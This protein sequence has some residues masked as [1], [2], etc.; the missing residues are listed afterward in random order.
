MG[1]NILVKFFRYLCGSSK[2]P[3]PIQYMSSSNSNLTVLMYKGTEEFMFQVPIIIIIF[4]VMLEQLAIIGA[5]SSEA[6][7]EFVFGNDST[8]HATQLETRFMVKGLSLIWKCLVIFS[9]LG[10]FVSKQAVVGKGSLMIQVGCDGQLSTTIC[11]GDH[12]LVSQC[13]G[14]I[15]SVQPLI[16]CFYCYF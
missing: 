10:P 2:S 14:C 5:I 16:D 8:H 9:M 15:K 1:S 4:S 7:T 3:C 12:Y 13:K 6:G 11:F